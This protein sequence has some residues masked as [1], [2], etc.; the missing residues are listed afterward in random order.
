MFFQ[1]EEWAA[2][3]P[4]LYF[5]N[6][7]DAELGRLVTEGRRREF[8]AFSA[9]SDDV[10]DPQALETFESSKLV[11]EECSRALHAEMLDWHRQLIQLRHELAA[12]C[13]GRLDRATVTFDEQAKWL[14][15]A[16]GPIAVA[17]NL[18]ERWQRTPLSIGKDARILLASDK[19]IQLVG[20]GI[21]L[22]PDSVAIVEAI[23]NRGSAMR[24]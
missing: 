2:S 3:S 4:F 5:T 14:V 9:H 19:E 8:A 13:D 16:R 15:M 20:A 11:W 23:G 17:C 24:Q 18:S 12:L 10:P 1:G 7:E 22:A 6:H 21:E